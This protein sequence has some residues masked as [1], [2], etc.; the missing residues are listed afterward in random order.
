M[1]DVAFIGLGVMGFPMAGHLA[2]AGHRVCVYNRTGSTAER[3]VAAH[4]GTRA[5]SPAQAAHGASHVFACV[6]NDD[7]VRA[8]TLGPEGAFAA[9]APD[10]VFVDH[11][12]ASARLARELHAAA[13]TGG[14]AS[15]DAPVSG[16]QSGAENGI[17]T[18]MTGGDAPAFERARPLIEC[19]ARTVCLLGPAGSGQLTKMVNQICI[20]GLIEA[21]A[22]GLHFARAVGLDPHAV[23]DVISKG[24]AQSWQMEN[25]FASMLEGRYDF[26]FAV[27]WVRK[28]FAIALDEARRHGVQLPVTALVDQLYAEVQRMGGGRWDTSSL[29][30]RLDAL[31]RPD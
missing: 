2:R 17:L 13:H 29:L 20:G 14:F 15:L 19:Y 23:I 10:A 26:G 16:G 6:G 4:G 9:I 8:V 24:A 5:A 22:E 3:W 21:L 28:D 1:A 12:T 18:V 25:R 11:T 30:A 27:D 31:R 7:D